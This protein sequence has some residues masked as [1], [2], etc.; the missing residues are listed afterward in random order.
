[1]T[2]KQLVESYV[3]QQAVVKEILT[4]MR[5]FDTE[6]VCRY[7]PILVLELFKNHSM[8]DANSQ[9]LIDSVV[10]TYLSQKPEGVHVATLSLEDEDE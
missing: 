7:V 8:T 1:M 9:T 6:S 5:K 3:K 2:Q 10:A 4:A